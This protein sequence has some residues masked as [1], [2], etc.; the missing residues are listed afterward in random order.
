MNAGDVAINAAGGCALA[1]A[2]SWVIS[3]LRSA[4][5]LDDD[6]AMEI[7]AAE[8]ARNV[9]ARQSG[10]KDKKIARLRDALFKRHPHDE[11]LEVQIRARVEGLSE[12]GRE[13]LKWLF[14]TSRA[15]L[16]TIIAAGKRDG[17]DEL[18][19]TVTPVQLVIRTGDLFQI[20]PRLRAALRNVLYPPDH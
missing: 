3:L 8:H 18:I 2:G 7:R 9:S 14:Y 12:A 5:L 17:F 16:G 13:A 6:R 4:R 19:S 10:D 15:E 11:E 20:N 1:F